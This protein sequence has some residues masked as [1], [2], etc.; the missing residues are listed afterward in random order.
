MRKVIS[1]G[2]VLE[3]FITMPLS[4][5]KKHMSLIRRILQSDS[6]EEKQSLA[7]ELTEQM[8]NKESGEVA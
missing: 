8:L 4:F 3:K 7:W 1:V 5:R 6:Y 2:N